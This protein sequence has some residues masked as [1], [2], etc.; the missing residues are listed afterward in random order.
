MGAFFAAMLASACGPLLA[1]IVIALSILT[2][3]E[4]YRLAKAAGYDVDTGA[5]TF[6]GTVWLVAFYCFVNLSK[7][8]VASYSLI[9]LLV[10]FFLLMIKTMFGKS[11]VRP[12]ERVAVTALGIVYLPVLLGYFMK[13]AHFSSTEP[14][15]MIRADI[16]LVFCSVLIVKLSDT[17]AF[18]VGTICAK[19]CGTH[20]LFPRISPK[21]SYEG[22]F[23]GIVAATAAGVFL[24]Y[25]AAL[26]QWGPDGI[27]WASNGEPAVTM[28]S[29]VF[30]SILFVAIGVFGD[31][32]ESMFKR[33]ASIKDSAALFPGMGGLLDTVD[34]LLFIPPVLCLF[35]I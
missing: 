16:F 17:A 19:T 26:R 33:A 1:L 6:L 13:V 35:L 3:L 28:T 20:P 12:F 10:M 22:L 15:H 32:V 11:A 31:L 18:A 29:A 25:A 8:H 21:K 9:L 34:S 7:E 14:F 24:T 23:G 27:F 2:Q 30:I 4:F 5:G